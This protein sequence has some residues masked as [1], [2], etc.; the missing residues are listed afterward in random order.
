[1]PSLI[2]RHLTRYRY[3]S[4][5]AFGEHRMM[6]RPCESYDQRIIDHRLKITPEPSELRS[7]HDVFGNA[8]Q[9]A[10]FNTKARE[11]VF[12]STVELEHA[13]EPPVG[14]DS[15]S[16]RYPMA[17]GPDD[18]PDLLRSI[19]R[20]HPDP[21]RALERWAQRFVKRDGPTVVLDLL[22]E[23]THT[24]HQE[25]GYAA[26]LE[27]GTQTPLETL[28]LGTGSCRD[29]AV[30]MIEAV[31]SL[32]FA[33]R[34]VSGYI[35]SRGKPAGGQARVGGGHTHAWV[36]VYLPR[37][38]WV[39]YDP[40]NG[41]VGGIDLVRVAVA[42]DPRQAVPLSGSWSGEAGDY[43]G[44]DVEVDVKVLPGDARIWRAA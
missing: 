15:K 21:E 8:V 4:P 23:M 9:I 5:V 25:F 30:L 42:R 32:G 19:E 40:T 13:P 1:M 22:A 38:G 12:E 11:L 29:L 3:A 36:R 31:R 41:I 2:V 7:M 28:H 33:A 10:R 27:V 44:M 35:Y 18:M 43:Q 16:A 39:E 34:F 26:R 14:D 17:Y 37:R 6:F 24:I 20:Q